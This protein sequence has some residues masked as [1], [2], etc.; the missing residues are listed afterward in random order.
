MTQIG[1]KGKANTNSKGEGPITAN[2]RKRFTEIVKSENVP[3][4]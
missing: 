3:E 1:T 4:D 2:L